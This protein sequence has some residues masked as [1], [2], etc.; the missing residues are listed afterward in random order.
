MVFV[1]RVPPTPCTPLL[2]WALVVIVI[3]LA[4]ALILILIL[5]LI[6]K[7]SLYVTLW[8][9]RHACRILILILILMFSVPRVS[10]RDTLILEVSVVVT[11]IAVTHVHTVIRQK[12]RMEK[13]RIS[14]LGRAS[15][16]QSSLPAVPKGPPSVPTGTIRGYFSGC[17]GVASC[18]RLVVIIL[19]GIDVVQMHRQ[20]MQ[21][22]DHH[23]SGPRPVWVARGV[24]PCP[25]HLTRLSVHHDWVAADHLHV[26]QGH[27]VGPH[28]HV[29]RGRGNRVRPEVHSWHVG[30]AVQRGGHIFR[31]R[32]RP[33]KVLFVAPVHPIAPLPRMRS[34]GT[35]PIPSSIVT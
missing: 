3:V 23:R 20:L 17:L 1:P 6:L 28:S 25:L 24:G 35:M 10:R 30:H 21:I 13:N 33:A 2:P 14:P 12:L 18:F 31:G 29:G 19:G 11:R 26:G 32:P 27:G 5:I 7:W 22:R 9:G 4:I 8:A 34:A 15:E 16:T